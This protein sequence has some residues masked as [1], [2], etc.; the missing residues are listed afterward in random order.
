MWFLI[1]FVL[2][3]I[4]EIALFVQIGGA[5]GVGVTILWVLASAALGLWI[6]RRQGMAAT[7]DLQ[8]ALA[9]FRDPARPLVH[10]ALVMLGGGLLVL[11]G[12]LTD[13]LGL[14]LLVPPVR[15]LLL[16]GLRRRVRV[17]A[18]G[19]GTGFGTGR[20]GTPRGRPT[21]IDA[22][23]AVIEE[24]PGDAPPAALPPRGPRRPS[25]WTQD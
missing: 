3:P 24:E 25:G 7:A 18:A 6:L 17:A 20:H 16:R 12:F 23:Y 8:R 19:L 10:G 11:P 15:S 21:V 2:W 14:L 1:P 4:V 13:A 5:I 9:E 22:E